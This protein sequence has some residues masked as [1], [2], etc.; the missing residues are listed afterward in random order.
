M[1]ADM[2]R[3]YRGFREAYEIALTPEQTA[4]RDKWFRPG[5]VLITYEEI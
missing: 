3:L 1:T 4:L 5:G 2:Q